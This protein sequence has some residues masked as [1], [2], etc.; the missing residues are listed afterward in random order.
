MWDRVLGDKRL[1]PSSELSPQPHS[2]Y[3]VMA[4]VPS[5]PLL[6]GLKKI[7][8]TKTIKI[9]FKIEVRERERKLFS[10]KHFVV[11]SLTFIHSALS[12]FFGVR[13][14][15]GVTTGPVQLHLLERL[16]LHDRVAW[17]IVENQL[18]LNIRSNLPTLNSIPLICMLLL[19]VKLPE[20]AAK[21][22]LHIPGLCGG[23]EM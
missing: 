6:L 12:W 21:L 23:G 9:S 20:T 14:W 13:D 17:H 16:F 11:L 4:S 1:H 22:F 2:L 5:F 7:S 19:H 10:S 3:L 15:S 18:T 8:L